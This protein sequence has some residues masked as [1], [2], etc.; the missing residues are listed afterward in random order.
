[1]KEEKLQNV[2]KIIKSGKTKLDDDMLTMVM[3]KARFLI[4]MSLLLDQI[5]LLSKSSGTELKQQI[6]QLS[7]VCI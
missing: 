1:M 6:G 2:M 3:L 5:M 7:T 4:Y